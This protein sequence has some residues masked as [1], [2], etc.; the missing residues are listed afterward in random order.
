MTNPIPSKNRSRYFQPPK[1][2]DGLR[3]FGVLAVVA[4]FAGFYLMGV[5]A[6]GDSMKKTTAKQIPLSPAPFSIQGAPLELAQGVHSLLWHY[7]TH[8]PE[9]CS[10]SSRAVNDFQRIQCGEFWDRL[11]ELGWV[12]SIPFLFAAIF[13]FL[14][15]DRVRQQFQKARRRINQGKSTGLGIVTDPAE[16]S[17]DRIS[18]WYGV[19]PI[20]VQVADGKQVVAYLPPEAHVPPPGE[21]V[22][23]YDWGKMGGQ[24]RF[25][26]VLY[27][28]HV[29]VLQG[30]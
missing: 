10:D 11:S 21:K 6:S 9:Q 23:L 15:L 26:A 2:S 20:T 19:Q 17:A 28:P 5:V 7:A 4:Y 25:F 8:V 12:S 29:A 13:L 22:A 1:L 14:A 27:A 30:G 16:A 24:K 3:R 18:W